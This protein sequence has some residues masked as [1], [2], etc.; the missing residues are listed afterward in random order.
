VNNEIV[1][2]G[3]VMRHGD[4]VFE[5]RRMR[6]AIAHQRRGFGRQI[7]RELEKCVRALGGTAIILDTSVQQVAAQR[8]YESEGY[9][10]TA[11]GQRTNERG[12]F[13]VVYYKKQLV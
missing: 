1:A 12:M 5:L 11:R 7:A 8:F 3:A 2:T 13:E 9:V 10:E 6:I 4:D